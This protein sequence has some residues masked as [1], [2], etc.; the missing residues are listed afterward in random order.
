[1]VTFSDFYVEMR[2]LAEYGARYGEYID[3]NNISEF[4]NFFSKSNGFTLSKSKEKGYQL[5]IYGRFSSKVFIIENELEELARH[6]G[7]NIKI[8]MDCKF[9][10]EYIYV[11]TII[12][13][14]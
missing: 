4:L 12:E 3:I 5:N 8:T 11:Q 6:L 1:M 14:Y 9:T 13:N 2:E 7:K 10:N